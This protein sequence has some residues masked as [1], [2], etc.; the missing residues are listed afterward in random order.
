VSYGETSGDEGGAHSP[1]PSRAS[2][3]R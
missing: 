3:S 1:S 2:S